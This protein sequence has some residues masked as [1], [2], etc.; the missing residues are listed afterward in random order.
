MEASNDV[1]LDRLVR[2][3][4]DMKEV[5][6]FMGSSVVKKDVYDVD[7]KAI[8]KQITDIVAV[9]TEASKNRNGII[10]LIINAVIMAGMGILLV[11]G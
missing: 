3:Q 4:D 5:K 10:Q 11:K 8:Q 9:Q 1:L 2:L 7:Q 6:G